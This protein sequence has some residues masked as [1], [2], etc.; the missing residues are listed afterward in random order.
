MREENRHIAA[1]KRGLIFHHFA[2]FTAPVANINRY[3]LSES[4]I[5]T[6]MF[7]LSQ[8]PYRPYIFHDISP[9]TRRVPLVSMNCIPCRGTWV[10]LHLCGVCVTQ[11]LIFYVVIYISLAAFFHL[12]I[13]MSV[14]RLTDCFWL[15]LWYPQLFFF[16]FSYL[17]LNIKQPT[18]N[19]S[20]NRIFEMFICLYFFFVSKY[21]FFFLLNCLGLMEEVLNWTI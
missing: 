13:A 7:R 4:K 14:L 2:K 5:T 19:Q 1:A 10:H 18:I 12:T 8:S 21:V 17:T 3:G 11:S 15:S 6:Y 9:V 16:N 20:I